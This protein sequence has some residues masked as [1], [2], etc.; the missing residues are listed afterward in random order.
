MSRR[1]QID[2]DLLYAYVIM[3]AILWIGVFGEIYSSAELS[4]LLIYCPTHN[5]T[6]YQLLLAVQLASFVAL[7]WPIL[8]VSSIII[9][10]SGLL[11]NIIISVSIDFV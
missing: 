10:I 11:L 6:A 3:G 7:L 8:M 4:K 1:V 2:I 9:I 5:C